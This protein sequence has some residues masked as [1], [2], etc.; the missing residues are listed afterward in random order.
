[1]DTRLAPEPNFP[2]G[3][4][5]P[6]RHDERSLILRDDIHLRIKGVR[7][8]RRLRYPPS[9]NRARFSV[10]YQ[11]L[12]SKQLDQNGLH[13]LF[14]AAHPA[15]VAVGANLAGFGSERVPLPDARGP[16]MRAAQFLLAAVSKMRRLSGELLFDPSREDVFVGHPVLPAEDAA[17]ASCQRFGDCLDQAGRY[18]GAVRAR[19]PRTLG[20]PEPRSLR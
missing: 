15:A 16:P 13:L 11:V 6:S 20:E 19:R 3:W 12:A 9:E 8:D 7:H 4:R 5:L 1:M 14:K 10:E 2:L 17:A 18:R